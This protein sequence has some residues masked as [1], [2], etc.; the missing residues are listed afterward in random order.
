MFQITD[1]ASR[2]LVT[3]NLFER[4]V[5]IAGLDLPKFDPDTV[6]APDITA[7][8]P[9]EI[10]AAVHKVVAAGKD[11]LADK[12]VQQLMMRK[13]LVDQ[14]GGF[15]YRT[16]LAIS[17]AK[18]EHVKAHAP[19]LLEQLSEEFTAAVGTMREQIPVIGHRDLKHALTEIDRVPDRL[20]AGITAA[21]RALSKA[22]ATIEALPYILEAVGVR[23]P[24]GGHNGLLTY[25]KPTHQQF[26]DHRLS[27]QSTQNN[28]GRPHNVWDL[29]NDGITVE[30]ATTNEEFQARLQRLEQGRLD[31]GRDYRKEASQHAEAKAQGRIFGFS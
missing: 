23:L 2:N 11:P 8:T 4:A 29:L 25:C 3:I 19:A 9:E 15:H 26:V 16:Q 6:P 18:M 10:S 27:S 21:F 20:A 13:L 31:A 14:V 12:G 17:K 30:L 28:H 22:T 24:S 7:A 1:D 5:K